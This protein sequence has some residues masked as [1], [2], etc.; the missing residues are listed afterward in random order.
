MKRAIR[1]FKKYFIPHEG[2]DHQPH[3]LRRETILFIG[4][5]VLAIEVVF[6][7]RSFGIISMDKL[8]ALILPNSLVDE[9][10]A[11]RVSDDL[12]SLK[13]SALLEA[14]ARDK[15]NDMAKNGYFAHT[16]PTGI[17][18]WYWF[19]KVGY[20]FEYA[21]EN[22]AINFID[23]KDVM[24]AWMNSPEHRANILDSNFT[25]IGIATAEGTYEG[26]PATFVVQLFG[27][28]A[29]LAASASPAAAVASAKPSVISQSSS[30]TASGESS[31]VAVKGAETSS[32]ASAASSAVAGTTE[33]NSVADAWASP[34]QTLNY[35]LYALG[36]LVILALGLN[37]FIKMEIQH[38]YLIL[39]GLLLIVFL[40]AMIVVNNY[41]ALSQIRIL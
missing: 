11:T 39:N 31:F 12:S 40:G 18:P 36:A 28:P 19:E 27:T 3:M 1:W 30:T 41:L 4:V 10:N 7:F 33:S 8:T 9:T 2:N 23:S 38:G 15:A 24:N 35:L 16:S 26:R 37:V 34:H 6:V 5:M 29:P 17:T 21:G 32:V 14:A 25:Q 22:L 13:P 20:N